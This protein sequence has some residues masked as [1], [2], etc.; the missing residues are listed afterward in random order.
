VA[1][2]QSMSKTPF[3]GFASRN[4][5]SQETIPQECQNRDMRN[6]NKILTVDPRGTRGRRSEHVKDSIS[7]FRE[8]QLGESR[9]N[10]T[11]MPKSRYAKSQQD[12]DR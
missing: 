4:L 9:N 3:R 1:E 2:D 11:G 8:S 6:H 7:G 12:L 10:T 5:E